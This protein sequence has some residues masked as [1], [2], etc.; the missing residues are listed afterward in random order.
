IDQ[1]LTL[2][3]LSVTFTRTNRMVLDVRVLVD[4]R[5]SSRKMAPIRRFGL[6]ELP[7][8]GAVLASL[9][10]NGT[11]RGHPM[12]GRCHPASASV[13]DPHGFERQTPGAIPCPCD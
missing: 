6:G 10:S 1:P 13:S 7:T 3:R 8:F 2:G 11:I 12:L 5:R 9:F 4:E